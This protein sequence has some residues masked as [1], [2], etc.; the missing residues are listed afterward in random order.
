[1]CF[2]ADAGAG[3]FVAVFAFLNRND[4]NV[5][6]HPF[7]LFEGS[8]CRQNMEMTVGEFRD[9]FEKLEGAKIHING[10]EVTITQYGLFDLCALNCLL[11][12]QN[13]SSTYT[14]AWTNVSKDHLKSENHSGIPPLM[15][16]IQN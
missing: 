3:R 8:D 13:H 6:L 10:Q 2:D 12:K 9:T 5:K 11:G 14:F 7:I 16:C 1:M 4:Q 15:Y